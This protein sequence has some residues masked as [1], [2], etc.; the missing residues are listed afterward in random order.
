MIEN[1]Y[2]QHSYNQISKSA[3]SS[4]SKY[5]KDHTVDVVLISHYLL[6]VTL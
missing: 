2:R 1:T 4:Y 6:A 3:K 5:S